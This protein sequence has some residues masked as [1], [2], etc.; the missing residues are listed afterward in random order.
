M[1]IR[2]RRQR[3]EI[4][5]RNS[6]RQP[7]FFQP[8][9]EPGFVALRWDGREYLFSPAKASELLAEL[10]EAVRLAS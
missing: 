10:R 6:P 5:T 1:I 8:I 3:P 9:N 4:I 7:F 2:R